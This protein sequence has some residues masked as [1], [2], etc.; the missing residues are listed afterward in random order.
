MR[1]H[2]MILTPCRTSRATNSQQFVVGHLGQQRS[3]RPRTTSATRLAL[4]SA[5]SASMRSSTVPRQTNLWTSTL[6]LLPD[7]EGA[8]GRLVLDGRVPPAVEVDHVRGRRQVQPRAARL[9]RQDEERRPVLALERLD[10][11][12]PLGRRPSPPCSTRPGRPKT[13]SRNSASGSAISRNC[14]KTSAFSCRSASSSHSSAQALELA[15]VL[16]VVVAVA[17]PLRRV[18]ADLLEAHQVGQHHAACR[19][20]PSACASA[21]RPG[22]APTARRAPPAA[23]SGRRRPLTSV[24]SGRSAMTRLSVLSRRRMY[25]RTSA[26]SGAYGLCSPASIRLTNVGER[27]GAA[28]QAGVEEVEQRP[29]VRQAVLDR[30]A[31]QGDAAGRAQLLRRPASGA[32]RGS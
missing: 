1:P 5:I 3:R 32:C 24:L 12:A 2:L 4:F 26:R 25:G 18:V 13:P 7:A 28:E 15:A 17:E 27:L 20:M 11:L 16:R 19:W 23:C 6:L 8:V 30:R 22:R 10:Q 14:V 29:Q 31:R 9:E 21:S